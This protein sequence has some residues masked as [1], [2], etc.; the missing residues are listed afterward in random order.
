MRWS[1]GAVFKSVLI[2][3]DMLWIVSV[4]V[5]PVGTVLSV[6]TGGLGW[7][8][9]SAAGAP[10]TGAPS[11]GVPVGVAGAVGAAVGVPSPIMVLMMSN[12]LKSTGTPA[13]PARASNSALALLR[14]SGVLTSLV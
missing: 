8:T 11:A 10:S 2:L 1:A 4:G 7:I 6:A 12:P 3:S 5:S 14:S 13:A 9:G